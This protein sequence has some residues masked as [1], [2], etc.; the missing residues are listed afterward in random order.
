MKSTHLGWS[1]LATLM[2]AMAA[3]AAE[4]PAKPNVLLMV[5]DDQG[6]ADVGFNGCKDVPT[7]HLDGLA[8]S[9]LQ[10]T[11]GYVSHP[12]CAPSR[13][14]LMTGRSQGRF[15]F[16]TN[17]YFDYNDHQEGLPTSERLLPEFMLSAGY[18]TGWIG[19]WHLGAA[20]EF[21][22]LKRGFAETF[23]FIGGGHRFLDWKVNPA[24]EFEVPIERNGQPVDVTEHLTGAFGHEASAFIRRHDSQ[25]WFLYLA[26]NAPHV[27]LEP[28]P[29]RLAR[30]ASITDPKRRAYAA[31]ISLLDDA[32]GE[33]LQTLRQT[34]Q[35][36]RTLIFFFSD[37]G[38]PPWANAASNLPLRG[39][40]GQVYDGGV[41]VPFLVAWPGTLP[42]N[43]RYE[44]AVSSLDVFA[45]ALACAGVPMPTDRVHDSVDLLPYLTGQTPGEPHDWLFWK[46][47]MTGQYSS[48]ARQSDGNWKLVRKPG[49]PDELYQ[50]SADIGEK[51]NLAESESE[52]A[53]S[54]GSRLTEWSKALMP[55]AF[56]REDR[57]VEEMR[58]KL[59]LK[60]PEASIQN[61]SPAELELARD[62]VVIHESTH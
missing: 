30:F 39:T 48:A 29:E 14:G 52:R 36:R 4:A 2:S 38:G 41:H 50:L 15:G 62:L 5:S 11:N 32:I 26:F 40:K 8:R 10:C 34:G 46:T 17:P 33:T 37:N 21:S 18:A 28:T 45:T 19:K 56:D 24:K 27:P 49:K 58:R 6:Y 22:P 53:A 7:P 47:T 1:V 43:R 35:E 12:F 60:A 23:G 31:Q 55:P 61:H 42:A 44:P 9:G 16:Y 57:W 59:K 13:A 3:A 20:P 51:N 54:I 25:P